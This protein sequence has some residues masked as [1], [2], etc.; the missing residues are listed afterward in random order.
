M[1][2][3]IILADRGTVKAFKMDHTRTQGRARVELMEEVDVVNANQSLSEKTTD[4]QGRHPDKRRGQAASQQMSTSEAQGLEAEE[5][6]K[7]IE[8]VQ[9]QI[10][11]ILSGQPSLGWSFAA[12]DSV[13]EE[14]LS[15]LKKSTRERLVRNET[16]NL[17]NQPT[18]EVLERF[19]G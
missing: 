5:E 11:R 10:E 9:E 2:Q 17:T 3:V 18:D 8:E 19:A 13:N 6:R 7:Q 15:G 12:A 14:I 4:Q 16:V 1:N